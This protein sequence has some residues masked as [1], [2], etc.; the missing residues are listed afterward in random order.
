MNIETISRNNTKLY[1]L[2]GDF[3]ITSLQDFQDN[4]FPVLNEPIEILGI[5]MAEVSFID[6]S[7]IGKLVQIANLSKGKNIKMF[8]IDIQG[9]VFQLLKSVRLDS[10][11]SITDK[12]SFAEKYLV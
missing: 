3:T 2:K 10:F 9:G 4:V 8:L 5:N 6:S 12:H 7:G 1:Y 11:F